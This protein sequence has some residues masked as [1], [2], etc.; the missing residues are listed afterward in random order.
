MDM[1]EGWKNKL[2]LA[3]LRGHETTVTVVVALRAFDSPKASKYLMGP[4]LPET[5]SA[6]KRLLLCVRV[7]PDMQDSLLETSTYSV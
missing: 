7:G 3:S 6:E 4:A 2:R 5:L 1:K